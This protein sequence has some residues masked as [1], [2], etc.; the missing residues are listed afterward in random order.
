MAKFHVVFNHDKCKGCEL[1]ANVCPKTLITMTGV[2]NNKGYITAE[3]SDEEACVGCASCAT[4]CPDGAI[5]IFK[6]D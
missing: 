6:E 1:C 3:M 4:M 2:L 5:E